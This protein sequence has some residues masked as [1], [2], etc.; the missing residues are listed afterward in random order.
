MSTGSYLVRRAIYQNNRFDESSGS[1]AAR[2]PDSQAGAA[3]SMKTAREEKPGVALDEDGS[4]SDPDP[5]T[6]SAV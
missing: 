6:K 4:D 2:S 1:K 3:A 5:T